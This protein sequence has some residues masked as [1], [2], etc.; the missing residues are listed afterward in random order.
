METLGGEA[1]SYER[2]TPVAQGPMETLGGGAVSYE[3]GTPVIQFPII[4][5]FL[6]GNAC[7]IHAPNSVTDHFTNIKGFAPGNECKIDNTRWSTTFSSKV[8]LHGGVRP[9]HQKSTCLT[10]LT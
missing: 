8:N 7:V 2:G 5:L 4:N 9:F 3:R 10:Q 1:V 6:P